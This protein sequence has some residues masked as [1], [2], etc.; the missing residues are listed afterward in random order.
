M[1]F[2]ESWV[3]TDE[4][5]PNITYMSLPPGSYTLCV[6]MLN[7]DGTMGDIESQL[8]INIAP[9]FY[10]SWW[11]YL[12]YLLIIAALVWW[13]RKNFIRKQ[14]RHLETETLRHE[15][16]K[17][18][19]RNQMRMQQ[20]GQGDETFIPEEIHLEKAD[21]NIVE[22]VRECCETFT[23]PEDRPFKMNFSSTA[24]FVL[25]PFDAKQLGDAL[26]LLMKN[27]A[28][29]C[30]HECNMQVSLFTPSVSEVKILIADNGIGVKDEY[31]EHVFDRMLVEG[32]GVGLDRVKAVIEAHGGSITV[33]DNPGG[34]TV[35]TITLPTGEE[36]FTEAVQLDDENE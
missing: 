33:D 32:E 28:H 19:L 15:T 2:N 11:A 35:F 4:V 25:V 9:P 8:E 3:R 5:N 31:K 7:D 18:Q 13:W 17:Q 24:E 36:E 27:S 29:F 34:G 21:R 10:R 12:I 16:E 22:F 1:G 26:R 14:G 30:P 20:M 23:S 6:R